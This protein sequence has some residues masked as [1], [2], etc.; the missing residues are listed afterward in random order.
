[1]RNQNTDG[2]TFLKF[3]E[4][5]KEIL[6]KT[7]T[8]DSRKPKNSLEK[9]STEV[10]S[11]W[12]LENPIINAK[13]LFKR[14]VSAA[15]LKEAWHQLKNNPGMLTK[16]SR[17]ETIYNIN[18]SF[19]ENISQT[20]INGTFK[21]PAA[22]RVNI[23]KTDGKTGTRSLSITNS[24]I[25]IIEK[26]LLNHLEVIFEGSYHW[27]T[28]LETE[29]RNA[30]TNLKTAEFK[31]EYKVITDKIT[32]KYAYKKKNHIAKRIF[33]STSFGF[34]NGKSAHQALHHIKTS[35]ISNTIYFL[36]YDIKKA[37]DSVNRNRLKNTFNRYVKDPRLWE[38]IE[39]ILNAGYIR[40]DILQMEN[41]G[42]NQASI[43]S[44]F[45]FNVYMHDFDQLMEDLNEEHSK[46]NR[47]YGNKDY[48]D[49]EAK[50]NYNRLM[51]KYSHQI[52][53][54]Y[55]RLGSQEKFIS[56]KKRE[57][58][59]HH[60]KY[61]RTQG[62]DL[63]NR[64][65]QYVRYADDL[66]IGIVGPRKFAI[67]IQK[68]I[69]NFIK[70]NLHL[71]INNN[72]IIH[73][74]QPP[75]TFLGHHIQ[76][77][78][79]HGK[80]RTKNKQLETIH[81]YKNKAIQQLKLEE[82]RIAKLKTNTFRNMMLKH[83]DIMSK[84]LN[85]K[86]TK[87][88]KLDLLASLSAYKF[89]G[90]ELAKNLNLD[91]L[92]ELTKFLSLLDS[93]KEL[94]N[95]TL[96]KFFNA[97]NKD[98]IYDQ[99]IAITNI[100]DQINNLRHFDGYGTEKVGSI[101][102]EIQNT[103]E[104]KTKA[105]SESI[106]VKLIE[107]KSKRIRETH[108]KKQI[109]IKNLK[110]AIP[111]TIKEEEIFK[112][113]AVGLVELDLQKQSVRTISVRANIAELCNKLRIAGF[114]HPIKNQASSCQKLIFISENEII[115]YYNSVMQGILYWF[116]GADNFYRVKGVMESVMRRS[117]LLTLKRKFKLKSINQTIS[118]YTKDVAIVV[119]D[120]STT[121]LIT[122]E[123]I[124]KIPNTFSIGMDHAT[125]RAKEHFNWEIIMNQIQFRSHGLKSFEQC[126]IEN[127]SKPRRRNA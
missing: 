115:K 92:G 126:M 84:E 11:K 33:K 121:K 76:L 57:F 50:K 91:S 40:N 13:G 62:I 109:K 86:H 54:T 43:L 95:P 117:C 38:E 46:N 98:I 88:K 65:I 51:G 125:G 94:K 34:R 113:I 14:A 119:K 17:N 112:G 16:G 96:K 44:P 67:Y 5:L 55:R 48:G 35:W 30:E 64:Y 60:K 8:I 49:P 15:K 42:I 41:I 78:N 66:L 18:N 9:K 110:S 80:I 61:G 53:K 25:K 93:S 72:E 102:K 103:I 12:V 19:F 118:I 58:L 59:K 87:R 4:G 124:T 97:I 107:D 28:I 27:N 10:E 106:T 73:R 29:F 81:R 47:L 21:Y 122:R 105:L 24:R 37:F 20:L 2:K 70:S 120:K 99:G 63:I 101:L 31:S 7:R 111:L 56:E 26:A 79:F 108:M 74:D 82:N 6:R 69:D 1:M 22:R 68:E 52:L 114:M 85:L 32:K 36:D 23:P 104:S 77:I 116:S 75:I 3:D 100:G 90:D 127:C 71:K 83:I 89:M 123:E 45:L 39:K